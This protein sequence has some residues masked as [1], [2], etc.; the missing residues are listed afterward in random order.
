MGSPIAIAVNDLDGD[1]VSGVILGLLPSGLGPLVQVNNALFTISGIPNGPT[2]VP[3]SFPITISIQD[4]LGAVTNKNMVITIDNKKPIIAP[5]VCTTP[6]RWHTPYSC[7]LSASDPDG[8]AITSFTLVPGTFPAGM[9]IDAAGMISGNLSV[10]G[11]FDVR[12]FATDQ[13]TAVSNE[14][15][16]PITVNSFCG[17]NIKQSPNTEN[18]GGP[19]DNGTEFCDGSDGVAASPM[20]SSVNRQYAC[21]TPPVCPLVG[22]CLGTCAL[23]GGYCGDSIVQGAFTEQC[24]APGGGGSINDQWECNNC[25]WDAG[26]CGNSVCDAAYETF[27]SCPSDCSPSPSSEFSVCTGVP[28]QPACYPPGSNIAPTI[29]WN[30]S[31]VQSDYCDCDGSPVL[32]DCPYATP[33]L[34]SY[35]ESFL[36]Q[37]FDQATYLSPVHV[38]G[39]INSSNLFYTV[40]VNVLLPSS[41]YYFRVK[42]KD[43]YGTWSD[44]VYCIAAFNTNPYCSGLPLVPAPPGG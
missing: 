42:V 27:S 13:Y 24:E 3:A 9:S 40:P 38:S 10:T 39:T 35:Q 26:W 28:T 41:T 21:T 16:F 14:V 18:R 17:D 44:W 19:A 20:D 4:S 12:V 29:N 11:T 25:A 6:A 37:I 30:V 5:P 15:S 31:A 23:T 32:D 7:A 34:A 1:N 33:C 43:Q 8:H 2:P 22:G 36:V